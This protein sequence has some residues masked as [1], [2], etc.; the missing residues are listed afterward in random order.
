VTSLAG[1]NTIGGRRTLVL[2][3]FVLTHLPDGYVQLRPE[4][5]LPDAAGADRG[6]LSL[7]SDGCLVAGIG[8]LLLEHPDGNILIDAGIGPVSIGPAH[9][10][11]ALGWLRGGQLLEHLR[12]ASYR[13]PLISLAFT[14]LHDDHVGWALHPE[15]ADG[16]LANTQLLIGEIEAGHQQQFV[17]RLAQGRSERVRLIVDGELIFP[18]V[19]A[20]L[21]PG[22]TPGSLI[23]QI[24]SAEQRLVVLG[25]LMHT[26]AQV[27]HP[28]WRAGLDWE[29]NLAVD[30]R[31]R[32]LAELADDPSAIVY[33]GHFADGVFGRVRRSEAG[34]EW[35]PL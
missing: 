34:Y 7:D 25:D 3:E 30:A 4:H 33:N 11:Q 16:P 1:L 24:A 5:W 9:T 35:E 15:A 22:H 13:K 29:P 17:M 26:S 28:H 27:K 10:I 19:T 8:G 6:S 2:G 32:L 23:F 21:V 14:H 20:R 18:G 31:N 12:A